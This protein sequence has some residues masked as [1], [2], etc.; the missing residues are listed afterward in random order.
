M[1]LYQKVDRVLIEEAAIIPLVYD[2]RH[3]LVKPWVRKYPTSPIGTS[4]WKDV[5]I[6]PH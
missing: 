2:R 1:R 4:F 5:I 6:E 3:L